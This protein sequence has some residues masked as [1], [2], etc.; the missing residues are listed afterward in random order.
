[1]WEPTPLDEKQPH[2]WM[3]SGCFIV[4]MT[5]S[6][7]QISQTASSSAIQ[8]VSHFS[9]R[10]SVLD[11][12]AGEKWILCCTSWHQ[13]VVPKSWPHCVCRCSKLSKLLTSGD[14][15]G[16]FMDT[17]GCPEAFIGAVKP[18]FLKLDLDDLVNIHFSC[19]A[20]CSNFLACEAFLMQCNDGCMS[21]FERES[22]LT[23][24]HN[25]WT[26]VF[27]PFIAISLLL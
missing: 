11:N 27:P 24:E 5:W 21:F 25:N 7:F 1:M 12:F 22:L 3:V 26:H 17:L 18:F 23:Q 8:K 4:G 14:G 6:I 15:T 20:L 19:N 16:N 2:S 10:I 13:A 9:C